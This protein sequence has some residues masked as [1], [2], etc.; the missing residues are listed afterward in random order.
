MSKIRGVD[1]KYSGVGYD[2]R[3]ETNCDNYG[4]DDYCRCGVIVDQTITSVDVQDITDEI[5]KLYFDDSPS[6]KRDNKI[7]S[8]IFGTGKEIDL[9]TIDRILRFHK[10][11]KDH[12]FDIG[13]DGGYYGQEIGDITFD[14]AIANKIES[15]I[16]KAFAISDINER[17]KYLLE[18]EYG[19]LLP[20]LDGCKYELAT[21]DLEDVVFGSDGHYRKIQKEDLDHYTDYYYKGIR[22]VVRKSGDKY[23]IIDGYHRIYAATLRKIQSQKKSN[24]N[25]STISVILAKSN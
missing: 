19:Y 8:I 23:K 4:C 1:F 6:T 15:E 21:I 13:I 5:Y 10:I 9:Y 25:L 12:V 14:N 18:L 17:I 7:N 24:P 11:W 20:E 16:D 2:Y 22:G 3:S